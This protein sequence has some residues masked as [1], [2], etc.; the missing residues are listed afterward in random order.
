MMKDILKGMMMGSLMPGINK[1]DL[2]YS[3]IESIFQKSRDSAM[4]DDELK[5]HIQHCLNIPYKIGFNE[6]YYSG[7]DDGISDER[8]TLNKDDKNK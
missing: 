2:L 5:I 4:D 1:Y 8:D 3:L 6:G 7:Y